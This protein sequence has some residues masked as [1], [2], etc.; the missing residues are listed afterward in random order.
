MATQVSV[1]YFGMDGVG[2]NVTEAKRD[3]GRKIEAALEGHYEPTIYRDGAAAVMVFRNP[4]HGWG[5]TVLT[6]DDGAIRAGRHYASM[7][8]GTWDGAKQRALG[9]LAQLAWT[10]ERGMDVPSYLPPEERGNYLTCARFWLRCLEGQRRGVAQDDLHA[11]ATRDPR[12]PELWQ[13]SAA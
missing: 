7:D 9:H 3:A 13:D 10:E 8:D 4:L 2:R 1:K 12:R 11:Y 6:D 5:H